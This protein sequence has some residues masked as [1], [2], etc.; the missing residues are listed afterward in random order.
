MY[1]CINT[2]LN[3][4]SI[5]SC[6]PPQWPIRVDIAFDEV[7]KT[8]C[9]W[10][11]T[12][13]MMFSY[14]NLADVSLRR[15]INASDP[16]WRMTYRAR[17]RGPHSVGCACPLVSGPSIYV[18]NLSATCRYVGQFPR[19]RDRISARVIT[20]RK[21]RSVAARAIAPNR[22]IVDTGIDDNIV[23]RSNTGR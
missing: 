19:P 2:V 8:N 4:I 21:S 18:R 7:Q 5:Q 9:S 17:S 14:G 16:N 15:V 1:V 3:I 10:A 13:R 6:S 12:P 23:T 20:T 11:L 22:Y